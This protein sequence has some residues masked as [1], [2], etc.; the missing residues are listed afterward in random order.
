MVRRVKGKAVTGSTN[1]QVEVL[2][3]E[4][5][6]H[7]GDQGDIVRVKPGYARNY[8]LPHGLA[9]VATDPQ[10]TY[11]R[12]ASSPIRS[13]PKKIASRILRKLKDDV[14]NYSVTVEANANEEGHLYGSVI[15]SDI[16]RMLKQAGFDVAP[17][18]I[19]LEGPLKELGMYTV[20][21]QLHEDVKGEV[22]V[23]VVP[24]AKQE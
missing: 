11:G 5:V 17:E 22:K 8:L 12:T 24:G 23:W 21:F 13:M 10:Q 20:K 16:S 7:L 9:T 2:L 6:T 18:Q 4:K 19:K 14:E 3:A 15:D 1:S